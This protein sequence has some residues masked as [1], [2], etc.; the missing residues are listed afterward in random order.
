MAV[1]LKNPAIQAIP[2][3]SKIQKFKQDKSMEIKKEIPNKQ[4]NNAEITT[5]NIR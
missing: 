5:V 2:V 3:T 1:F 4:Q